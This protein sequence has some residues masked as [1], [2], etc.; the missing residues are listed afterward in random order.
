MVELSPSFALSMFVSIGPVIPIAGGV[1]DSSLVIGGVV[2]AVGV[3]DSDL[4]VF[5]ISEG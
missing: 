4:E 2:A 5:R 1:P 3:P